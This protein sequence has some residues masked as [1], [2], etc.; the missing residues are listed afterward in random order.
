MKSLVLA[1]FALPLAAQLQVLSLQGNAA[2]PVG[3]SVNLGSAAV[4]DSA[5]F[6][7]RALNTGAAPITVQTI[8][9]S[10]AAFSLGSPFVP[11]N[12]NS[13]QSYDF[14][15][16]FSPSAEGS[17]SAS[18]NVN[19]FSTLLRAAAV[20]GPSLFITNSG[21]TVELPTSSLQVN[22]ASGQSLNV[23]LSV[24]NPHAAPLTLTEIAIAGT[25]FSL[26]NPPALPLV[27]AP[28][29]SLPIPVTVTG[30]AIGEAAAVLTL[31]PRRFSIL[32]IVFRPLLPAPRILTN[33]A[34]PRNGQQLKVTLQLAE[35]AIGAGN[36]TL[37]AT[38]IG[39]VDDPAVVFPNGT[40]EIPFA[41]AAG[42]RDAR[43]D[44]LT[45][46]QALM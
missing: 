32:A 16:R 6:L 39:S 25:G 7:F 46:E 38:F 35:P 5:E 43:R 3:P 12:L 15:V 22:V 30:S 4:R 36:G 13:A 40:R 28:G 18:L 10:G 8:T 37:R 23:A 17:Y 44:P 19:S 42:S 33:E 41:I 21:Q 27:L 45:V 2:I 20:P 29:E 9:V 14:T 11:V 26:A 1:L 34:L 24:G 31:G